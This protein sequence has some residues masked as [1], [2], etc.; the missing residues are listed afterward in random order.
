M[1]R[2]LFPAGWMPSAEKGQ[3]IT[4]CTGIG[5]KQAWLG[6]D[7]VLQDQAPKEKQHGSDPD[8]NPC[9]FSGIG[10]AAINSAAFAPSPQLISIE[11]QLAHIGKAV[12]IGRG[13]AAPPPP[14][15]GPP[16]LI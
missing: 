15:T 3:M 14:A 10:F 7:G 6:N 12:T 9:A 5:V 16:A 1:M 8:Q 11:T 4:L 2:V 13:L